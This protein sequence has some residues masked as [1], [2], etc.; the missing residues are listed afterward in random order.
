VSESWQQGQGIQGQVA[1]SV[2]MVA[3]V[4][5]CLTHVPTLAGLHTD[6]STLISEE[7]GA[8]SSATGSRA[9][10]AGTGCISVHRVGRGSPCLRHGSTS[11][12]GLRTDG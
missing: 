2:L 4:L 10:V 11:C 12:T 7:M 1:L 6:G 9:Q 8:S 5:P 3:R